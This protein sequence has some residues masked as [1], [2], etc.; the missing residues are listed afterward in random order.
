MIG[1]ALPRLAEWARFY[2]PKRPSAMKI[3]AVERCCC[4]HPAAIV[5]QPTGVGG[6]VW[7]RLDTLLV[8]VSRARRDRRRHPRPRR[9]V[10]LHRQRRNE[11][12][13]PVSR[14][15]ALHRAE[16]GDRGADERATAGASS[17]RLCPYIRRQ[18]P[19]MAAYQ[20]CLSIAPA[21]VVRHAPGFGGARHA[22][23][24][25]PETASNTS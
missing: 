4:G 3:A 17:F 23:S 15:A 16:R 7:T 12:A 11:E 10:R 18:L 9:G 6:K 22:T 19:R 5:G 21:S 25:A 1:N 2:E 24:W 14:R 13:D 8:R 20:Q